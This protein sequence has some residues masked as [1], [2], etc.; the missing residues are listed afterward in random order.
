MMGTYPQSLHAGDAETCGDWVGF[1][2]EK[3]EALSLTEE[4]MASL[5]AVRSDYRKEVIRIDGRIR[6]L[7]GSIN[8]LLSDKEASPSTAE[9]K[10]R[11]QGKLRTEGELA[12][13]WALSKAREVLTTE[14]LDTLGRLSGWQSADSWVLCHGQRDTEVEGSAS[15]TLDEDALLYP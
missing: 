5:K 11:T 2:L 1:L 8:D 13:V 10:I 6:A 14:Q 3:A 4:Q 15:P 12:Y 7:Q 9:E